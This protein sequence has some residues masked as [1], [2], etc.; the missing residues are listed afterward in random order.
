MA[1]GGVVKKNY[2]YLVGY[3]GFV[4]F[5]RSKTPLELPHGTNLIIAK[6]IW[7]PS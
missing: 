1:L 6:Q 7:I 5:T 2:R 3:K 4:F